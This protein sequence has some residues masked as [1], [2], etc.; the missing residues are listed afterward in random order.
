MA[1]NRWRKRWGRRWG[2]GWRWVYFTFVLYLHFSLLCF[3]K[4]E[5]EKIV[6]FFFP[7]FSLGF[8]LVSI[9]HS[10]SL[11]EFLNLSLSLSLSLCIWDIFKKFEI[12]KSIKKYLGWCKNVVHQTY[13]Y[14]LPFGCW[15]LVFCLGLIFMFF[16]S[17]VV[18]WGFLFSSGFFLCLFAKKIYGFEG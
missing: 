18:I 16:D 7:L 2:W 6:S 3:R 17:V 13:Y 10:H 1:W 11:T 9:S 4:K 8:S 12:F 14:F 15:F 5:K